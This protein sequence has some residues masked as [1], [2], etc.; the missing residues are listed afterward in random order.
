M[1]EQ[2]PPRPRGRS[3]D[4]GAGARRRRPTA[5]RGYGFETLRDPR[6]A[7]RPTRRP[8][9]WSSPIYLTSTFAQDD[10]G[11]PPAATST[12]ARGNPTRT[13]LETCLAALEGGAH[14]LAFASGMAAEDCLLRTVARPGDHVV[15]PDDAYGG[16]YRLFAKVLERW[17]VE[18]PPVP[19]GD[20]DARA[21]GDAAR[22]PRWCGSRRR[23]TRCSTSPTS[24]RW[25]RS[26]TTPARGSSSTTR[27]PRPYLQQPLALGADVVVHST[28]KYLGG[29]SD[30]V[31]G[32]LVAADAELGERAGLL[33]R[34]RSAR[35]RRR[36]TAGWC[37]AASRRSACA[38]TGTARTP[39]RSS[40]CCSASPGGGV[41][42]STRACPTTPATRSR[43]KQMRDFGGMVSFRLR[44]R[45]GGRA[46]SCAG[47][48]GCSRWPS[49]SAA[50]S[51]S[52]STRR[53]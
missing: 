44:R 1:S 32:A 11:R 2:T 28:T 34:T 18:S 19:L 4:F 17:G 27:S 53:G 35:A 8:A 24:R 38:W 30:V 23:P 29:H 51:R 10:V 26:R 43:A 42:C 16:T 6:R 48:P 41:R 46:A 37:C 39:Q 14:G 13:A 3:R 20:L 15:I 40:T 36:S 31:G 47:A 50:S 33:A 22:R 7:G 49:R 25:P 52:S 5:G 21:R 12:A 9:R 45:R